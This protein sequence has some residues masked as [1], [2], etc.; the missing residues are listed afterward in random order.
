MIWQNDTG[1]ELRVNSRVTGRLMHVRCTILL[2]GFDMFCLLENVEPP[3]QYHNVIFPPES[4]EYFVL[5]CLGPGI[6]TVALYK[7]E[8][9]KPRLI[10]ILQNNTV[11]RVS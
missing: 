4:L 9:P 1:L 2:F 8:M 5:E 6:P 11:L 10:T 7:M 3:C